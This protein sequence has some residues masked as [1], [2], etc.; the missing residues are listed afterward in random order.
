MSGIALT[1]EIRH[2]GGRTGQ[3]PIIVASGNSDPEMEMDAY[4]A[5]ADVFLT[6][7]FNLGKLRDEVAD[8]IRGERNIRS[9][10][11]RLNASARSRI[12]QLKT[13]LK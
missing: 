12:N 7:P 5:G 10:A 11:R 2:I 6:K 4:D 8:A 9:S 1:E 3:I 13:R